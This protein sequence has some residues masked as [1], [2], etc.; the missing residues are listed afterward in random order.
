MR[1][2]VK[3]GI[4]QI[5]DVGQISNFSKSAIF[6][7]GSFEMKKVNSSIA[8]KPVPGH[9]YPSDSASS[10]SGT[11]LL[12]NI[13]FCNTHSGR[14]AAVQPSS[15]PA[16]T[17]ESLLRESAEQLIV[18]AM[19]V[20]VRV[21]RAQFRDLRDDHDREMIVRNG[22]HPPRVLATVIG[23][24]TVRIPKLRRRDGGRVAFRSLF[25][26]HYVRRADAIEAARQRDYLKSI[27]SRDVA[28][29]LEA[30]FNGRI[31]YLPSAVLNNLRAWWM[32]HCEAMLLTYDAQ[33]LDAAR[34]VGFDKAYANVFTHPAPQPARDDRPA[35]AADYEDVHVS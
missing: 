20:E 2:G 15:V 23:R 3:T 26:P 12:S 35:N 25:V 28:A 24:V 7:A 8:N 6:C 33:C 5:V 1:Y 19:E 10:A 17:L 21:F 14:V 4:A 22:F 9:C 16:N 13:E 31:R 34:A 29:A 11:L 30:L 18:E 27:R 32:Q